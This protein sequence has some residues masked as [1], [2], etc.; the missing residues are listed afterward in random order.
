MRRLGIVLALVVAVAAIAVVLNAIPPS[1]D[2]SAA[3]NPI[4]RT[5]LTGPISPDVTEGSIPT[6]DVSPG[7]LKPASPA[8]GECLDRIVRGG[9]W[10]DLC[11][12]AGRQGND[13]DPVRDSYLLQVYGSYERVRWVVV[14]S[15]LLIDPGDNVFDAWPSG[16]YD[17]ACRQEQVPMLVPLTALSTEIVCGHTE[18]RIDF[19]DWSHR[20]TWRCE[21]CL[22]PDATTR[23]FGLYNIVG[24]PA[25]TVPS[26]DLY[27][28][29]G[30]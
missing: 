25:G 28:E 26:W 7:D 12:Q 13:A 8:G 15:R 5:V 16:T 11:W 19:A 4:T 22:L 1:I 29:A 21:G 20:V 17:G 27:A 23:G 14:G 3:S 18:G 2:S 6:G 24:V 10:L 9:G 30:R